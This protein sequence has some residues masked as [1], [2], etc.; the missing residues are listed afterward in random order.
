MIDR[1]A[2]KILVEELSRTPDV[3]DRQMITPEHMFKRAFEVREPEKRTLSVFSYIVHDSNSEALGR[4]WLY[5]D[6][7]KIKQADEQLRTIIDASPI[8]TI[9]SRVSDG[10]IIY[11]N[12]HL[13]RL[14]GGD[15]EKL[16]G[17]L[18][19]NFYADPED[20]AEVLRL[21]QRDGCVENH[22]V[23]IRRL[24]GSTFWS[25][26]SLTTTELAGDQVIIGG[27][28]DISERK[29]FEQ[30]LQSERNFT[31]AILE[32]I[33]ALVMVL[34][35]DGRI[36]RFNRAAELIG[37]Y[38]FSEVRGKMVWEF[39]IVE[40]E[41]DLVHER[42][43]QI[44]EDDKPVEGENEWLCKDG[45]RR[46]ISWLNTAMRSESGE[47]QY[48]VATGIDITE[49][50]EA[51]RNLKAAHDQLSVRLRYEEGLAACSQSLLSGGTDDDGLRQALEH[52]RDA[53]DCDRAYVFLNEVADNG[54]LVACR[55][56]EVARSGVPAGDEG[57]ELRIRYSDGFD[58]VR[59]E[60]EAGRAVTRLGEDMPELFRFLPEEVKARSALILPITVQGVWFGA[61]GLDDVYSPRQWSQEDIRAFTTAS[62]MLGIYFERRQVANAL[63]VSELRFRRL[64]E[65][66]NDVIFSLDADGRFTYLSP[67][68]TALTG[69]KVEEF[70]GR[71][72]ADLM[73]PDD[74][75][76]L[77]ERMHSRISTMERWT[78]PEYRI[79]HPGGE[80]RWF[81]SNAQGIRDENDEIREIIGI[82]ATN[83]SGLIARLGT[84][85]RNSCSRR[86]WL[87]SACW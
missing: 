34:D 47:V 30:Q 68:F 3:M 20:R 37:G 66:A 24:D 27:L 17:E 8:P 26:F 42:F 51:E 56:V 15:P 87:R 6:I 22:E 50:K 57:R 29:R 69:R 31:N 78:S 52:L 85:S 62:E 32:T 41:L 18:T 84:S 10:H 11:T 73:H 48:I 76:G 28:Y 61:V 19:P 9:V 38:E 82:A 71:P 67:R 21:L 49:R 43:R 70:I 33:A 40:E 65:N 74:A 35:P 39:L 44:T 2:Y 23:L 45:S 55:H 16:I 14:V 59:A 79:I 83:W 64:V 58:D 5:A 13:A 54:E 86:K 72:A 7:T 63:Q 4:V 80:V 25:L 46:H 81:V 12:R 75:V 1:E 77:R 60:L 53:A 36:V